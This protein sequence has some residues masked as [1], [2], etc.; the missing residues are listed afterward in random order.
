M[1]LLLILGIGCIGVAIVALL[2]GLTVQR[3]RTA[4]RLAA[5]D[6]YGFSAESTAPEITLRRD[7]G[8]AGFVSAIGEAFAQR[9]GSIREEDLRAELMSAGMYTMSPRM[10]LGYRV[11]A[12]LLLPA[13]VLLVGSFSLL[14][15]GLSILAVFAGWML[16]LVLVRRKALRGWNHRAPTARLIDLL[17]VTDE[18][19][20]IRGRAPSRQTHH[21][22]VE[23]ELRLTLQEQTMGLGV[24]EA[25]ANLAARA[26][27]PGMRTF[28]CAMAQG[29][30]LGISI[31]HVMRNLAVDMR[32]RRRQMAEEKA[33]KAP[34]KMLFPLVFMIFPSL[35]I[36][37]MTP[38]IL[39]IISTL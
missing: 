22:P 4:E 16:P 30:R 13:F 23:H 33:Q 19:A 3:L 27:T 39:K 28:V 29:E 32:K 2:R 10:L 36:V 37:L 12:A 14:S 17:A 15:I 20:R 1:I 26:D 21:R 9:V 25:L 6:E 31:G 8:I 34:I 11:I 5:I 35:F 38:A 18:A 7:E 24:D